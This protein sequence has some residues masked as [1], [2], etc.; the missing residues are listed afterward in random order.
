MH[1]ITWKCGELE[2]VLFFAGPSEDKKAKTVKNTWECGEFK[3]VLFFSPIR[4]TIKRNGTSRK[5]R[6]LT[7]RIHGW[8]DVACLFIG[9]CVFGPQK[10]FLSCI[11]SLLPQD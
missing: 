5:R 7:S 9:Y 1:G 10:R 3:I 6:P 8:L 4:R 11:V 2:L